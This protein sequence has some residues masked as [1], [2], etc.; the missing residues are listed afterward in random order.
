MDFVNTHRRTQCVAFAPFFQ[1]RVIG[2]LELL[3]VPND[4][5]LLGRDFKKETERVGVQFDAAMRVANLKFIVR[6]LPHTG[7]ENLP[8]TRRPE[9]AHGMK[10][11]IPVIEIANDADAL[12]IG[13]PNGKAG[14]GN[15]VNHAELGAEF[16]VNFSLVA[17]AEKIQIG[18]T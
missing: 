4:G 12:R 10:S 15:S 11:S 16:F 13:R 8:D 14:P 6:A 1:P 7:D 9:Q 5:G 3:A 2:P 17:L 18:F